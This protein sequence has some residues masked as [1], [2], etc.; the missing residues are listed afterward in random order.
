MV[1]GDTAP[2]EST[3]TFLLPLLPS[4]ARYMSFSLGVASCV[5]RLE[6]EVQEAASTLQNRA[7]ITLHFQKEK[8]KKKK[9][10]KTNQ[11]LS[12]DVVA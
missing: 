6:K 5:G 9:E 3:T 4:V 2:T 1:G 8:T 10:R 11:A 12:A 7:L